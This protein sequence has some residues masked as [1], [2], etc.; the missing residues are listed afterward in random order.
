MMS[1]KCR[2]GKFL[3]VEKERD[4]AED[5]FNPGNFEKIPKVYLHILYTMESL[6]I[7]LQS[8]NYWGNNLYQPVL[9]G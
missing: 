7:K 1:V 3:Y 5:L 8:N 2:A 6:R 4:P 9:Q